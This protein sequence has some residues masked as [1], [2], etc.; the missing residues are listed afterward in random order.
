MAVGGPRRQQH[1]ELLLAEARGHLAQNRVAEAADALQ[2]AIDALDNRGGEGSAVDV[3]TPAELRVSRMA[4]NGK[5]N[6]EI[7]DE[8]SVTVKAIEYHLANTYRKLSIRG[9][10]E[11][12]RL[13]NFAAPLLASLA[14]G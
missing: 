9:R 14:I 12:T 10:T 1:A 8:L 6:R 5:K 4:A 2:Q 3:L 7:A 11:L 13:F